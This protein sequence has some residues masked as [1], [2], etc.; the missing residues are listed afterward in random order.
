MATQES[1][2]CRVCG[3]PIGT[4][5]QVCPHCG[6][7]LAT[8]SEQ[9][10]IT[11]ERQLVLV[12]DTI[13]LRDLL[14]IIETSLAFWRR[15]YENATGVA[16]DK[17]AVALQELSQILASL[18]QQIAQ[19]RETVHITT[20]LPAQR[21]YPLACPFCGRGN[22]AQARFCV[23]CGSSLQPPLQKTYPP[24]PLQPQVAFHS[25]TGRVRQINEDTVY[26]GTFSRGNEHIGTLL[27]VADGMGGASAGEV[28]SQLAV[29][30]V[31]HFLQQALNK[32]LP[33][34][35]EAWLA[36]LQAAMQTAHE[37]VAHAAH[38]DQ[39]RAGMGTTLTIALT[40]DRR[41]YLGHIGD[42]RA[43]LITA[44]TD[45]E[46][47]LCQQLTTDHTIVARLVDIG[48]ISPEAARTHP[49]RHILYR[50]LGTD[51]PFVVDTRVQALAPGDILLLC[52]DGLVNHV[53]DE[54]LAQ[55]VVTN[56]PA[57]AAMALVDLANQRGGH[58]NIS[59]IIAHFSA[60]SA[61]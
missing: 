54:E 3:N 6:S 53:T 52:S 29:T 40:V 60:Q 24:P 26:A 61:M 25:H 50:S 36:L 18:G 12:A 5:Q 58:D 55:L 37:Q 23:S 51:Q 44:G 43:Y 13:S 19:G 46:A 31:K 30:T 2:Q 48:Q 8:P 27:I 41:A 59:I 28:A 39:H 17:A 21:R 16:R 10:I 14:A 34:D 35:D 11:G 56:P 47:P 22:R 7:S 15:R 38:A 57:R 32:N 33:G 45:N 49:Q 42:S 1:G 9:V 4:A 20:R